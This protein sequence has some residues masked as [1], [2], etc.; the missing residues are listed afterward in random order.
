M[1]NYFILALKYVTAAS[2]QEKA[3]GAVQTTKRYAHNILPNSGQR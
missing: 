2:G 3:D 1:N